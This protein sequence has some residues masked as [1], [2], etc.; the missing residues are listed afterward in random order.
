[1]EESIFAKIAKE[2]NSKCKSGRV[3]FVFGQEEGMTTDVDYYL[4]TGCSPLDVILGKGLPNKRIIE[5]SGAEGSG[6]STLLSAIIASAQKKGIYPIL[7]EPEG[8]NLSERLE[9]IGIEKDKLFILD[10]D[11]IEDFFD[12]LQKTIEGIKNHDKSAK[13]LCG[14]DSLATTMSKAQF[15]GDFDSCQ[16]ATVARVM[17]NS[18]RKINRVIAKNDV[19]LI[20]VNQVREKIGVMFGE[21]EI[22]PGG[23]AL[24]F[25]CS[26][27]LKLSTAEKIKDS[28]GN[29][30]G[31]K[32][33]I[34]TKKNKV[35]APFKECIAVIN[36]KKGIVNLDS[37]VASLKSCRSSGFTYG[38]RTY[39]GESIRKLLK[40]D[41]GARK[42]ALNQIRIG[43]I[44]KGDRD[45]K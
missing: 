39:K 42:E 35:F 10:C 33:R 25:Y 29:I 26:I 43:K 44:S 38:D 13:I 18:I 15:E 36:F 31:I 24:K 27:R 12:Q 45:E 16:V 41:K 7:F 21:K 32:T 22:T 23:R 3:C 40:S 11:T 34:E 20:I 4:G 5:I 8:S 37:I 17:S 30:V 9:E 28:S 14:W 6:K 2:V 19:I 1:M